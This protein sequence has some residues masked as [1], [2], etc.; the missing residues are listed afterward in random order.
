MSLLGEAAVVQDPNTSVAHSGDWSEAI[1][2]SPSIVLFPRTPQQVADALAIC[3]RHS[4]KVV[5]QGGLTGLAGGAT[6]KTGEVA[7][8]LAKL[9]VIEDIDLVGG[10][11]IVQAGVILETLQQKVEEQG[12]CFPLD[13]GARGSCQ[14]GGNAAVNAGGNRVIR[15][16]VMRQLTLGIEVALPDGRLIDMM[17]RVTKNTTGIDLKHLFIGSEGT[18]GVITRIVVQLFPK[19]SVACT[20]LCALPS[21]DAATDL[22]RE[23]RSSLPSLS[24]FEVMWHDFVSAAREIAHLR[25]PFEVGAPVYVLMETLGTDE[26]SERAQLERVLGTAIERG[27]VS[28]AIVAQSLDESER[29]WIY[30]ET[31]GELLSAL[32]P[33]AAFDV[34]IPM[35]SMEK[36]VERVRYE[37]TRD[38]PARKH[39]FFGHI[40]DG[41][42][43]VLSGPYKDEAALH[44]VEE[45][46][47]NAVRD[48]GGAISAEHGIGVVKRDFLNNSRS[49]QEV[50]LMADLKRLFD[51]AEILNAGRVI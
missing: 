21:F 6:P 8:S 39:L 45:L 22:I 14:I 26:A 33:H 44:H 43:H 49:D 28:D 3:S 38:F 29:L 11:A 46:V 24:A 17:N 15:Y 12:W 37:L 30:R 40:G 36:F 51:P 23:C 50:S 34:G 10:T 7:L 16:G 42:L 19:P 47:Y 48:F 1:K 9:N 4:K 32:K 18:L 13:L 25:P 20:A 31:V 35:A 27:M 41:N 2:V 5:V